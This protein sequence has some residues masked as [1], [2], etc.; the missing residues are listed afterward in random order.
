MIKP[1]EPSQQE[2]H[3]SFRSWPHEVS[4]MFHSMRPEGIRSQSPSRTQFWE[5]TQ[6]IVLAKGSVSWKLWTIPE[7]AQKHGGKTVHSRQ[8]AWLS[9]GN[10]LLHR[11]YSVASEALEALPPALG[12]VWD[13]AVLT[14]GC[15]SH[16][17]KWGIHVNN[18]LKLIKCCIWNYINSYAEQTFPLC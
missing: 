5:K 6:S 16:R 8:L 18:I 3:F 15:L 11:K 13:L 7:W 9:K 17:C 2:I 4:L 14:A 10:L 12:C 1:T